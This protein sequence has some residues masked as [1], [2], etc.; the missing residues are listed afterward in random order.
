VGHRKVYDVLKPKPAPTAVFNVGGEEPRLS[1]L[2][3]KHDLEG[4]T[5]S[6]ME[7]KISE[8]RVLAENR[9]VPAPPSA[10]SSKAPAFIP[11]FVGATS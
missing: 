7:Q 4:M 2:E 10:I 3:L 1:P 5:I 9:Q 11:Q 6:Q 8:L